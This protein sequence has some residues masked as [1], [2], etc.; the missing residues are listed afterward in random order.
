MKVIRSIGALAVACAIGVPPATAQTKAAPQ[1]PKPQISETTKEKAAAEN[2]NPDALVLADFQKRVEVYMAIHRDAAKEAPALKETN[3]PAKIK[4]AQE[5]FAA[6]I[7]AARANARE[8]DIM[9]PEIRN[10]FRRLMYSV[11]QGPAAQ[12][13]SGSAK[14]V[15]A[16]VKDELKENREEQQEEGGRPVLLKVN[17]TYPPDTPLPST[18]PQLLMTLP[19]LPEE[20]EYRIVG[21]NLIIRDIDANIIVDFVPNAI[22]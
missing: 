14:A 6:R 4:R 3:D 17:A 19:K 20:L 18:P 21:K 8:G 22:Q 5:A 11:V 15:K 12:G 9:T 16:D 10:K 13:T 2:A 7:R 1:P